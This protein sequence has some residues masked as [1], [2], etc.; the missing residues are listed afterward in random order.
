MIIST[1]IIKRRLPAIL[2]L[3]CDFTA[4]FIILWLSSTLSTTSLIVLQILPIGIIPATFIVPVCLVIVFAFLGSYQSTVT[5][6]GHV[7]LKRPAMGLT[8]IYL[9]LLFY[10]SYNRE[11]NN[12]I[13]I[14][15]SRLLVLM[16]I[17]FLIIGFIRFIIHLFYTTLLKKGWITHKIVIAFQSEPETPY[18]KEFLRYISLNNLTLTGY[19]GPENNSNDTLLNTPFLGSFADIPQVI[20]QTGIDEVIFLDHSK[21]PK[22]TEKILTEIESEQ[23]LVRMVPGTL[24]AISGQVALKNLADIP[25]VSITPSPIPLWQAI[26]K[27]LFDIIVALPGLFITL[28]LLPVF[29]YYIKKSSRGPLLFKQE[30]LGKN[31]KPF[32]LLKFRTMYEDAEAEGPQLVDKD[33]DLRITPIGRFLRRN[34][35]DELPQFWN[36]LMGDMSLV[37]PRPER[38]FYARQLEKEV[39]YYRFVKRVKPGLTSLGMVKYGYAH[40]IKEMTE[41]L[42]F[43]I[44]YINK[45]SLILDSQIIIYTLIYLL[46]KMFFRE[47]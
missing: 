46:K 28:L 32:T 15:F 6:L 18:L 39:P 22:Q 12:T 25:V 10:F 19:C 8:L 4:A 29:G 40:N 47:D 9:S 37:G 1:K 24:E 11:I 21:N 43:D 13:Y 2:A 45:P 33:N 3:I 5:S 30:R 16:V 14:D 36:I 35:L 42:V 31:G 26:V 20:K 41:R 34:H 27:R 44:I 17:Y 38:E 7:S 23:T